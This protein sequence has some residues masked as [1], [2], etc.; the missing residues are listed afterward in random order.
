MFISSATDGYI[1]TETNISYTA[2]ATPTTP[3]TD[4]GYSGLQVHTS[5]PL[6]SNHHYQKPVVKPRKNTGNALTHTSGATHTKTAVIS[7]DGKEY[8]YTV[9]PL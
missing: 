6:P 2:Q 8:R 7:R 3:P 5:L 4:S 9:E 1:E